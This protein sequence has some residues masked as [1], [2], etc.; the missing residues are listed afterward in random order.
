[1]LLTTL[2]VGGESQHLCIIRT[3]C[4]HVCSRLKKVLGIC[5]VFA[6]ADSVYNLRQENKQLRKAHHDI[7]TQL[8]DAQVK[9][10]QTPP[11]KNK[12]QIQ[13]LFC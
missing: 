4:S 2:Q 13:S 1:M 10:I 5:F 7:H 8:Q 11:K 12:K 3:L 6:I 9:Q